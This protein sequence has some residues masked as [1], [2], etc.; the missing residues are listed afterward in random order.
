MCETLLGLVDEG[1]RRRFGEDIARD[2]NV[3]LA[4]YMRA[5]TVLSLFTLAFF[6]FY[7]SVT[8]VPYRS[9]GRHRRPAGIHPHGGPFTAAVM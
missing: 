9:A 5:L 6:S 2:I 3:L 4:Q 1:S 7:F 8:H